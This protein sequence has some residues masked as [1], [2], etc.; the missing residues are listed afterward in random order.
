MLTMDLSYRFP[1][2]V[3]SGFLRNSELKICVDYRGR[4]IV[5]ENVIREITH[6]N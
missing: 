4:P 2:L 5:G 3:S 6:S 1:R